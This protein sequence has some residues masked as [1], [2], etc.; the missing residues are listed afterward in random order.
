M[1]TLKILPT[2]YGS[3]LLGV[4]LETMLAFYH[5]RDCERYQK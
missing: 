5:S 3:R 1:L 4:I 2:I